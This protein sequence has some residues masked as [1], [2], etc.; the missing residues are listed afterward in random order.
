[1]AASA[2]GDENIWLEEVL[3]DRSL[4]WVKEQSEQA[5][6][7]LGEP[8]ASPLY[9]R[10]L[11]IL[12]SKDKIPHVRK[13]D[14][15]YYNFWQDDAH[16]RGIWRRTSW[17]E[18]QKPEPAWELVL[19][20]DA[21]GKEEGESWVY[22]GAPILDMDGQPRDR[23]LMKLSRAGA[24]ATVIREF[25]L[26][27]KRFIPE[28]EGG[29]ILPE[30]KS[31]ICWKDRDTMYVGTD[32][33]EGSLTDSGYPRQAKQW[34]RGTP[35]SEAELIFE[36]EKTDIAVSAEWDQEIGRNYDWVQRAI[37]FYTA[38]YF[39]RVDGELK[40]V[41][42][43]DHM[44]VNCYADQIILQ[45]RKDWKG[46]DGKDYKAGSLVAVYWEFAL[47]EG[48][49][50]V[51]LL[52]EPTETKSLDS[53]CHTRQYLLLSILEDV[54]SK[55]VI[56]KYDSGAFASLDQPFTGENFTSVSVSP[57]SSRRSDDVLV[58][59][60]G[61]ALPEAVHFGT[62]TAA[63]IPRSDLQMLKSLPDMFDRTGVVVEQCFCESKDGTR[64]PYFQIGRKS[65]GPQ[66]TILYGYGGFEVSLTPSY[67][68][69]NGAGWLEKGYT[70]VMCNI[71]GG[72]EYG[73]RWH[74]AALKEK[75]HKAYEDFIA[76]GEDLVRRAVCKKEQLGIHGGSNGGLLVGNM[77]V[78][79]PDLWGSVVCQ[80]PLLDMRRYHTLLA[81]ASWMG[82]YGN[83]DTEDWKFLEGYSP[84]H[85]LKPSKEQAYPQLF[86]LTSTR[87]D[88][89]HPGHARKFVKRLRDMGHEDTTVYWENME[90]GHGGAADAPQQAY[91]KC[92]IFDFFSS[93][94]AKS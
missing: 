33:G 38:E 11:S 60:S 17:E 92:L 43:P 54:Q 77:F 20:I 74:Q 42:V 53:W 72:G 23:A 36:G 16:V 8:K 14:D 91:M 18:Y 44:M 55:V 52:F 39:L 70:Y 45:L 3:G 62:V 22:K 35:L 67:M 29:F 27:A 40:K 83:P 73:P 5:I 71:R 37:T 82:E 2:D 46:F 64:V 90:G 65:G 7:N 30:A 68:G 34:K 81:G 93:N 19:D 87:D 66:P 79:R 6:K 48:E 88:R 61:F 76:V 41:L 75:R 31:D 50:P 86:V 10:I 1:M 21:L 51:T 28:A 26:E 94:I 85:Q 4:E 47:R 15:Y 12:Q 84:Y 57:V 13:V 9:N 56:F 32:F 80:V 49:S 89:V 69:V 59:L 25:D 63:G 58:S 78:M 24:D